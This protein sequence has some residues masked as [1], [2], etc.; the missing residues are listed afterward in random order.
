MA[1]DSRMP[2]QLVIA[3]TPTLG[4]G[5]GGQ[6]PDWKLPGDMAY[7][8]ELTSRT[9]DS[10]RQ[11]AVIMGRK[12]WES[13]PAKF[14]P[15]KGRLNIVLSRAFADAGARHADSEN[16]GNAVVNQQQPPACAGKQPSALESAKERGSALAAGVLGSGSLDAALELLGSEE[17]HDRV[18]NVFIIGG[19]QVYAEALQHPDC[20]VVHLTQEFECDT[21]LPKLDPALYGIWSASQPVTG[22]RA[23]ELVH[24]MGDAHVYA[25]HVEPLKEQLKNAPRHFPTLKINPAKTDI[26]SFVFEDF[27]VV[28]YAPHATIKMKMAV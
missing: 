26:D 2:F 27:E 19:G 24:V 4:I 5:K 18:E 21:F 22:L 13:I 3:A 7:F 25:N 16:S 10:A 1:M 12:T 6:L 20:A 23:G 8:K 17:L 11:N 15:L 9:R 28:G 14:R